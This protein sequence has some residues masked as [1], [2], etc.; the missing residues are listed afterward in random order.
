[1]ICLVMCNLFLHNVICEGYIALIAGNASLEVDRKRLVNIKNIH[2]QLLPY[3]NE[4]I[5]KQA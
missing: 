3:V 5:L 2:Q 1:M 4:R